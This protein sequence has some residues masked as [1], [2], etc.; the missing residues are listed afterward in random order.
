[1][2]VQASPEVATVQSRISDVIENMERVI[3]G[4]RETVE[5]AVVALLS[6]GHLL[7]ED[8]PGVGKTMLAVSLARSIDCSY[9]RIQF[10]NDTIPA[11]ILGMMVYSR[12][13]E[14]F[15]FVEGPI[16]AGVVLAD[17]I[18]RTSPKTQSALLEAMTERI[19]SI[20]N[21]SFE[22]PA[23]FLV[24]ATQNPVEHHGT[25]PLPE[26][27]LDRFLLRVHMGYPDM[28]SEKEILSEDLGP[29]TAKT[30]KTVIS[31]E[32]V[33]LAQAQVRAV[34]LEDSIVSYILMLAN[35]TRSDE[36]LSLGVSPR[37][38][39]AL[40]RAVQALA[41]LRGRDYV[42]PDDVKRLVVP[43]WAHRI[44]VLDA[45]LGR[46]SQRG[47]AEIILSD[48]MQKAVVPV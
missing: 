12:R 33:L 6:G 47:E 18:N 20:E 25:F 3:R 10:T 5:L 2:A 46:L 22:L 23:P 34:T 30:L 21:Q 41:Y 26:S 37:G 24:I 7:L 15:R 45:G 1:M 32:D 36:R 16:F 42:L 4:K 29:E 17:E 48:L 35:A 14:R 28:Q 19:I 40:K 27:Q 39:L 43:V 9:R 38:T 44:Q 13:E 11:D 8:I 31:T